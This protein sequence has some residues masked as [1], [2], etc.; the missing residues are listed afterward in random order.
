MVRRKE[1]E[2]DLQMSRVEMGRRRRMDSCRLRGSLSQLQLESEEG[3]MA[4]LVEFL[5][6]AFLSPPHVARDRLHF[7]VFYFSNFYG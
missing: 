7:V 6:P 3:A 2:R 4:D 1:R 5:E